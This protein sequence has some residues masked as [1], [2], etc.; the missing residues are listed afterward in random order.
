MLNER[1][2]VRILLTYKGCFLV[3]KVMDKNAKLFMDDLY[4]RA[5]PLSPEGKKIADFTLMPTDEFPCVD[6]VYYYPY[7]DKKIPFKLLSDGKVMDYDQEILRNREK[8]NNYESVR[9]LRIAA[10]HLL[11][12]A[13]YLAVLADVSKSLVKYQ[14][15]GREYIIDY[16]N[17][18]VMKWEDYN[19]LFPHKVLAEVEQYA[20][21]YFKELSR[22]LAHI[23]P[24]HILLMAFPEVLKDMRKNI[25]TFAPDKYLAGIH[26][27]N[28]FMMDIND[29][30][31]FMIECE[32]KMVWRPD[33]DVICFFT[34]DPLARNFP[35]SCTDD[36]GFLYKDYK[37]YKLSD[38]IN[39]EEYKEE[40]VTPNRYHKCM[41]RSIGLLVRIG[42]LFN[43]GDARVVLGKIPINDYESLYHAWVEFKSKR[44]K[45]WMV[46]DYTSNLIM[47]KDKYMRLRDARILDSLSYS[48]I[49][50][51]FTYYDESCIEIDKFPMLYFAEEMLEAFSKNKSLYKSW[52]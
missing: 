9:S 47:E 28:R 41:A 15:D 29:E 18:V 10:S 50:E 8:R 46:A 52:K 17:N 44:T 11:P 14:K 26:W 36:N 2:Y 19:I 45:K 33:Y 7:Q 40:L 5:Q 37:F 51:L 31:L 34:L 38:Y 1:Y 27:H 13:T 43:E 12:G 35:I 24:L 16:G 23:F 30:F 3:S 4:S 25:P 32:K 48:F 6:G 49:K 21:S 42:H 39:D 22:D 20:L